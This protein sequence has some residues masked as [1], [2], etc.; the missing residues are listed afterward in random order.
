M[1]R[2]EIRILSGI[3]KLIE[4]YGINEIKFNTD[5]WKV[6]PFRGRDKMHKYEF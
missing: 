6:L 3:D 2:N 5:K 4:Q 1:E